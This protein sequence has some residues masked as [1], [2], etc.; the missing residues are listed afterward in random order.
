MLTDKVEQ[1][2]KL[3][4]DR[5]FNK[6]QAMLAFDKA[7]AWRAKKVQE[8]C[9]DAT[10]E[11]FDRAVRWIKYADPFAVNKSCLSS[12]PMWSNSINLEKIW[13]KMQ[14]IVADDF[15]WIIIIEKPCSLYI[16][17]TPLLYCQY[18]MK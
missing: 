12:A 11:E 6:R 7:E 16:R 14:T 17:F 1:L 8:V 13:E 5:D 2:E 10:D 18:P 3:T 9:K 15:F 4:D